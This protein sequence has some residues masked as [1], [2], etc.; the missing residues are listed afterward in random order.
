MV[1]KRLKI[2][3]KNL[4]ALVKGWQVRK[5]IKILE[6]KIQDFVNEE[7]KYRKC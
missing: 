6:D 2:L 5:C 4:V 7:N 3:R 1:R